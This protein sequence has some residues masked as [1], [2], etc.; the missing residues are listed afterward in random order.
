M[1]KC[2]F[3]EH[4]E[5]EKYFLTVTVRD[6]FYFQELVSWWIKWTDE[7][8]N[9]HNLPLNYKIIFNFIDLH[10]RH[11]KEFSYKLTVYLRTDWMATW[12]LDSYLLLQEKCT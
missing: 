10:L 4:K 1:P 12:L 7:Q 9:L 5:E 3:G 11:V 8:N 2:V 6:F